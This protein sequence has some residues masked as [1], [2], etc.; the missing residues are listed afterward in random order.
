MESS[1]QA[2]IARKNDELNRANANFQGGRPENGA[3]KGEEEI[4]GDDG[5]AKRQQNH[6]EENKDFL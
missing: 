5:F 3:W 4:K 6:D 2:K 1:Q